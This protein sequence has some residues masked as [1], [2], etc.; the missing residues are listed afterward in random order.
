MNSNLSCVPWDH[1]LW[2]S[3]VIVPP[4]MDPALYNVLNGCW[5]C[6]FEKQ[7]KENNYIFD[8]SFDV[9][10]NPPCNQCQ[11]FPIN[12]SDQLYQIHKFF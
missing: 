5:L 3:P 12:S 11:S 2:N 1:T 9:K 7:D 8:R 10:I 4:N 6:N